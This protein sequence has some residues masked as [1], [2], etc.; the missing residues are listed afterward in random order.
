MHETT[1]ANLQFLLLKISLYTDIIRRAVPLQKEQ[2][3]AY[4]VSMGEF[5]STSY[6]GSGHI[7]IST[8]FNTHLQN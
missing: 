7:L 2:L 5:K 1:T 6:V 3:E 4:G 8:S